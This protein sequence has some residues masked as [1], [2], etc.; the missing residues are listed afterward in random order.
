MRFV[1]L[2]CEA[3]L[4]LDLGYADEDERTQFL[5]VCE[6]WT[7]EVQGNDYETGYKDEGEEAL[8]AFTHLAKKY[9]HT[10]FE[11]LYR[12]TRGITRQKAATIIRHNKTMTFDLSESKLSS[13]TTNPEVAERFASKNGGVVLRFSVSDFEI[14]LSFDN[15]WGDMTQKEQQQFN[16]IEIGAKESEVL[17]INPPSLS[18][19]AVNIHRFTPNRYLRSYM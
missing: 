8:L 2:L 10:H 15:L 13:W 6:F 3:N 9:R 16:G 17:V 18:V 19:S 12:G 7:T 5:A 14:F 11:S 4:A 1:E